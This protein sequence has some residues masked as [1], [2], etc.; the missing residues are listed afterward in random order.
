[1]IWTPLN[2]PPENTL[3][4]PPL[5]PSFL[6]VKNVQNGCF[7]GVS[8]W[9]ILGHFV[10][11]GHFG[12]F[13]AILGHFSRFGGFS[14]PFFSDP[15]IPP[16]ARKRVIFDHFS[17]SEFQ[18]ENRFFIFSKKIHRF[19]RKMTFFWLFGVRN[20][21]FSWRQIFDFEHHIS[22]GDIIYILWKIWKYRKSQIQ[23]PDFTQKIGNMG[24]SD[25][26]PILAI[27]GQ[28]PLFTK[29][30]KT[31]Y[32]KK[33]QI[34][35]Q[36]FIYFFSKT[37]IQKCSSSQISDLSY[38]LQREICL[39]QNDPKNGHFCCFWELKIGV[40]KTEKNPKKHDFDDFLQIKHRRSGQK[41]CFLTPQ[42]TLFHL[43][44]QVL[45]T[46]FLGVYGGVWVILD[47]SLGHFTTAPEQFPTAVAKKWSF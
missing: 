34:W 42:N 19:L 17:T 9:F 2:A 22:R 40:Q 35:C 29:T 16:P 24:F 30:R 5:R 7:S 23:G 47:T 21:H 26:G 28:K 33:Q 14:A 43:C 4:Q 38:H 20:D 10:K 41:N 32:T 36:F 11:M 3:Q 12:A 37:E 13:W 8:K 27:I 31:S 46:H 25:R 1:M 6:G 39:P 45:K 15:L 18:D 44:S